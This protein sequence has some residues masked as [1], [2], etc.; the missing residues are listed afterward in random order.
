MHMAL[1][2]GAGRQAALRF[3]QH[4]IC[5]HRATLG[6][7]DRPPV[8]ARQRPIAGVLH[9]QWR[10]DA[11]LGKRIERHASHAFDDQAK[12]DVIDVGVAKDTARHMR[13]ALERGQQ[14]RRLPA[15]PCRT[16]RQPG[17]Q[18]RR[19]RQQ[20]AQRDRVLAAARTVGKVAQQR[21]FEVDLASLVQQQD[22]RCRHQHLR[23]RG[24]VKHG[25]D[26]DERCRWPEVETPVR[27]LG[28]RGAAFEPIHCAGQRTG[29]D[30]SPDSSVDCGQMMPVEAMLHAHD[31]I[32]Y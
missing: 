14:H 4:G 18:A 23:Q 12:Q 5:I 13:H 7:R 1:Q 26:S 24:D 28:M 8:A 10:K 25:V 3:R 22:R 32:L 31:D 9:A 11:L 16:G 30:G 15:L 2:H 27:A 21:R 17:Q 20:L 29:R 19:M 6:G